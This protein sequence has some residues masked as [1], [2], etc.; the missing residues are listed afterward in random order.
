MAVDS[1]TGMWLL[2]GA[3]VVPL[4]LG[5]LL[6]RWFERAASAS[7]AALAIGVAA[8]LRFDWKIGLLAVVSGFGLAWLGATPGFIPGNAGESLDSARRTG[9][10]WWDHLG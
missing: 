8:A 7:V 6:A 10:R 5:W 4:L 2:L 1:R 9:R 3:A